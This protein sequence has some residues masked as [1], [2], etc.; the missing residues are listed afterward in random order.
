M[1]QRHM[2]DTAIAIASGVPR[3]TVNS[4]T[5]GPARITV[6]VLASMATVLE[7][8]PEVFWMEPRDAARWCI[9]HPFEQHFTQ[10]GCIPWQLE[11]F[12][13]AA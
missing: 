4:Y 11:L 7:V 1:H 8:D 5:H 6:D 13:T 12:M 10:S 9:E 2:N 3:A